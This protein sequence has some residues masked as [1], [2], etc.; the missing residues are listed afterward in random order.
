VP[1]REVALEI[2]RGRQGEGIRPWSA[3]AGATVTTAALAVVP[4]ALAKL[5]AASPKAIALLDWGTL[6]DRPGEILFFE[7]FVSGSAKGNSHSE[8]A[9]RAAFA[10][11][12]AI[13]TGRGVVSALADKDVFNLLGAGLL[14]TGWSSDLNLLAAPC[15][16]VKA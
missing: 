11:V 16:V 15:L 5:R 4:Y 14:R 7:A 12:E 13:A 3:G 10:L 1:V 6:P 8:D 9:R 2:L